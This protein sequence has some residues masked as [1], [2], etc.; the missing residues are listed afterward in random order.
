MIDDAAADK[1]AMA[2][3]ELFEAE[4]A[5]PIKALLALATLAGEGHRASAFDV[6]SIISSGD[7]NYGPPLRTFQPDPALAQQFHTAALALAEAQDK[8]TP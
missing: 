7:V 5:E 6:A 3:Y 2:A 1:R 4:P 8:A